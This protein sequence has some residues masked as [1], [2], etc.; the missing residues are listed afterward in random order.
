M[1][2][3]FDGVR[4]FGRGMRLVARSPRFIALGI[5]PVILSLILYAG[6]FALL[7]YFFGDLVRLATWYAQDWSSAFWR[8]SVEAATGVAVAGAA[9]LL[10]IPTFTAVTLAIGDPFYEKISESIEDKLGGVPDA[11]DWPWWRSLLRGIA[12][13]ARL[14]L[15]TL[16][17]A[18]PLFLI[19]IIPVVGQVIAVI[20]GA[21]AGGW[22]LAVE[23]VGIPFYRRG[24]RLSDRRRML[25]G[26][27]KTTVG[28]GVAVF[29]CFLIPFGTILLMPAAV[30]GGTLLT[31]RV[32]GLPAS[33]KELP[34]PH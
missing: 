11:V 13:S 4:L 17:V 27:R 29:L 32:F 19:G 20:L 2:E 16:L 25:R 5:V 3:F 18:I 7:V 1:R 21:M 9:V 31:R 15:L 8:E 28:F 22:F 26:R 10:A 12:D 14:L 30:A 33:E 23:L 24:L 6:L 34:S